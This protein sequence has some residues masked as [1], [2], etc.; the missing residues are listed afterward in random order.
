MYNQ[1]SGDDEMYA[2]LATEFW[3]QQSVA[4]WKSSTAAIYFWLLSESKKLGWAK[5]LQ[6]GLKRI[7][8][9]LGCSKR[10]VRMCIEQLRAH[11]FLAVEQAEKQGRGYTNSYILLHVSDTEKGSTAVAETSTAEA[12]RKTVPPPQQKRVQPKQSK[13]QYAENVQL[14]DSEYNDLVNRHGRERVGKQIATLNNYKN[15]NGKK[16][17][18]DFHAILLWVVGAVEKQE[19]ELQRANTTSNSNADKQAKIDAD[20]ERLRAKFAAGAGDKPP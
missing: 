3:Q 9:Q 11:G 20:R 4:E 5:R 2:A 17:N 6:C 19:R 8:E 7:H 14:Y 10:T 16:Y 12:G 18:S 13:K 1:S 15:A